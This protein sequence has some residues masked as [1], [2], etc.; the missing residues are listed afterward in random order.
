M[1]KVF[2]LPNRRFYT[3]ATEYKNVPSEFHVGEDGSI[4]LQAIPSVIDLPSTAGVMFETG[5]IGSGVDG[6]SRRSNF[7]EESETKKLRSVNGS[8]ANGL[9][10]KRRVA[11]EPETH[12][13]R[14]GSSVDEERDSGS[15]SKDKVKHYDAEGACSIRIVF[16]RSK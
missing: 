7:Q 5:G 13:V 4:E 11:T 14:F 9:G 15:S 8:R 2:R 3:P 12:S 16:T 10:E 6:S 1:A